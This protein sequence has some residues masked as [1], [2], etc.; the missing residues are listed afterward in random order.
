MIGGRDLIQRTLSAL[1]M[2]PVVLA[3]SFFGGPAFVVL[4][5]I[6]GVG[7]SLEWADVAAIR[8]RKLY[9]TV[10]VGGLLGAVLALSLS[11]SLWVLPVIVG[12]ALVGG[13]LGRPVVW[14][15]AGI[16]IAALTCLP[17]I[18][19]RG[20]DQMGLSAVLFLYAVV[21]G[22]DIGAY[23]VGR[24]VGG[25]KLAPHLSP[26]K[27]WSGALGGGLIGTLAGCAIVVLSGFY[28]GP[29]VALLGIGLS[30]ASQIGDLAE[31]AFKRAFGV[32]D[33][34]RLIPGHG[35]ILDRVDG[36]IAAGL[37]ALVIGLLRDVDAPSAGLLLW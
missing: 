25:P 26:N 32:K 4:W 35:G 2:V 7:V 24:A 12:T 17:V 20:D 8:P 14:S 37:L 27:T 34:S 9:L 36:F 22:T 16:L 6:A 21:W 13:S 19:L 10:A 3:V 23:F 33:A 31:S 1:I 18:V 15:G 30:V 11:A 5:T 29:A 28:I